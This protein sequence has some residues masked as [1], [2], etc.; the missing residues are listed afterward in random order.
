MRPLTLD[1]VLRCI[2]ALFVDSLVFYT[3]PLDGITN[4]HRWFV[5]TSPRHSLLPWHRARRHGHRLSG[6]AGT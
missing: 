6:A 3:K 2:V 4:R 1:A 5:S